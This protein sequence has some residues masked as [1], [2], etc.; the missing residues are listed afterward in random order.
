[1]L[2]KGWESGTE[3]IS[4]TLV[5]GGGAVFWLQVSFGQYSNIIEAD[6]CIVTGEFLGMF[7]PY[8]V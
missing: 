3:L 5:G 4:D 6:S 2:S 7:S 8:V 1:M